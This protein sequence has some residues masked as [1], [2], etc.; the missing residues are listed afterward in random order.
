M[1]YT[2][3]GIIAWTVFLLMLRGMDTLS[4]TEQ[5]WLA[6]VVWLV[7]FLCAITPM[8]KEDKL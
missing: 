8:T 3:K 6:G 7:L 2:I 1:L 5:G 4:A